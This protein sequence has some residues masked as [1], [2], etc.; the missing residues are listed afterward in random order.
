LAQLGDP[1]DHVQPFSQAAGP[2]A[3]RS[4]ESGELR[5]TVLGA[6]HAANPY[7]VDTMTKAWNL[8]YRQSVPKLPVT[9]YYV[10][11]CPQDLEQVELL[12][13][14]GIAFFDFPLGHEV[15]EPGDYYPQEN[16]DST[17]IP[18]FYAVLPQGQAFPAMPYEIL[19]EL[20]LAP[21]S[22]LL[23]YAAFR[24]SGLPHEGFPG[25]VD[26]PRSP[27]I[28]DP[29]CPN[30]ICCSFGGY[31]CE[32]VGAPPYC[33]D[34]TIDCNPWMHPENWPACLED[35]GGPEPPAHTNACGCAIPG[36]SRQ[37]AGCI[38]VQDV[39]LGQFEGVRRARVVWWDGWF[40]V[41][42]AETS[43][44]GCWSIPG[45]RESGKAYMWVEFRNSDAKLRGFIGNT[46]QL[47]RAVLPITSYVGQLGGGVY[48]NILVE[49]PAWANQGSAAHRDWAAGS[50][51][52]ALAEHREQSL[53]DGITPPPYLDVYLASNRTDGFAL[54]K[55]YLGPI[56]V[57]IAISEGLLQASFFDLALWVN[58]GI[59]NYS[60]IYPVLPDMM[61]GASYRNSDEFRSLA[62]HELAHASHF[63]NVG[64]N[65][66]QG[67]AAAEIAADGWGNANSADA[68][69][70]AICESWAEHIAWTYVHRRY[71]GNTSI[72][73]TWERRLETTRNHFPSHVPV[74][75]HHDLIDNANL[76]DGNA[77]DRRGPD[78]NTPPACGMVVDNVVSFT[79]GQLF[80]ILGVGVNSIEAYRARLIEELLPTVPANT[81]QQVNGLFD[82][83]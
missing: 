40:R 57:G 63:M 45:H 43:Q 11:F 31:D 70:I 24:I 62:Y 27:L 65:Y 51:M 82:S 36:P 19:E 5:P 13:E 26:D 76:L 56:R 74:G 4:S 60:I 83:Y 6:K 35:G 72:A 9:D 68:G 8:L 10:R 80:S 78:A 18:C 48:N 3:F 54:M 41:R 64:P 1:S 29:D 46:V 55:R 58:Y 38:R 71:Q 59:P 77:C 23:A 79:N 12:V 7:Q 22:S 61:I 47:W 73:G 25:V 2:I 30:F 66:W 33:R 50:M 44:Q 49:Y 14:S 69:R 52:N 53:V 37:P 16:L 39:E 32:G 42:T 21:Y 75:L 15:I 28:C 81:V 17:A 34:V 67:L 20:V